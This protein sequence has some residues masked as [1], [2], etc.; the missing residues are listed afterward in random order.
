MKT[1]YVL[2]E[3]SPMRSCHRRLTLSLVLAAA[4]FL[5]TAAALWHPSSANLE[6]HVVVLDTQPPADM[7]DADEPTMWPAAWSD[8]DSGIESAAP[9]HVYFMYA[10]PAVTVRHVWLRSLFGWM[11]ALIAM[12][13]VAAALGRIRAARRPLPLAARPVRPVPVVMLLSLILPMLPQLVLMHADAQLL[14][15]LLLLV[16]SAGAG[17]AGAMLVARRQLASRLRWAVDGP[18]ASLPDGTLASAEVEAKKLV[19]PSSATRGRTAWYRA[20]LLANLKLARSEE[21]IRVALE[22][23]VVDVQAARE[24]AAVTFS[25]PT[26]A[27]LTVLGTTRRVPSDAGSVDPMARAPMQPR[28]AGTPSQPTLVFAGTRRQLARRLRTESAIQFGAHAVSVAA[29]LLALS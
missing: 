12:G 20:D 1:A 2:L 4:A 17:T 22:G 16:A 27:R 24:I 26:G 18:L 14:P 10:E 29:A 8:L 3:A 5:G 6:A 13:L 21:P 9:V 15:A 11:F 7:H 19:S 28:L 23:A 25:G